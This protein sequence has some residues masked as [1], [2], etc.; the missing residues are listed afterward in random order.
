MSVRAL[1]IQLVHVD[2]VFT[3]LPVP[4]AAGSTLTVLINL[5][6]HVVLLYTIHYFLQFLLHSTV[7][8]D[9]IQIHLLGLSSA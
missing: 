4:K 2:G 8:I 7:Q 6:E 1:E 5:V 3:L 9:G